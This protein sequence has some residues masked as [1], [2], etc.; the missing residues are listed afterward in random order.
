MSDSN[1]HRRRATQEFH[2]GCVAAHPRAAAAHF[3]LFSMHS[4]QARTLN[5]TKEIRA[6]GPSDVT[7]Y[8]ISIEA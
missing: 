5:P 6:P 7:T 4:Q 3:Q 1:Y 8:D 2:M